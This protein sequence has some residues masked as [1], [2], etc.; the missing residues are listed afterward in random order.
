MPR[1]RLR[2]LLSRQGWNRTRAAI[3]LEQ[4]EQQI[5]RGTWVPP[6][7]RAKARRAERE[8]R[9]DG[10]QPFGAFARKVVDAKKSHGLD[11]DTIADV[12]WK[13]GYLVRHLGGSSWRRSTWPGRMSCAT[14]WRAARG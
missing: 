8:E 12:E 2:C 7:G 10:R 3:E 9:P 13:L 1:G 11:E 6:E 4:I 5:Q 14:S